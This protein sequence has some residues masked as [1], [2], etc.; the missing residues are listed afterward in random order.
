M[1]AQLA[2]LHGRFPAVVMERE[3]GEGVDVHVLAIN[4]VREQVGEE[5]YKLVGSAFTLPD[6]PSDKD[7]AAQPAAAAS[8]ARK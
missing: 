6:P 2:F 5:D 3:D 7:E 4:E 8:A 1:K